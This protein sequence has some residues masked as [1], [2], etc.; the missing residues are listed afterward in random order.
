MDPV[1]TWVGSP[2]EVLTL[3]TRESE[4]VLKV[5]VRTPNDSWVEATPDHALLAYRMAYLDSLDRG[6][7]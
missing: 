4:S 7:L 3:I 6:S 5:W 2:A 1:I